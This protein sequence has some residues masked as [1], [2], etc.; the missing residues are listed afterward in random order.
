MSRCICIHTLGIP[1]TQESISQDTTLTQNVMSLV[2]Q[3]ECELVESSRR[4]TLLPCADT[5]TDS[6]LGEDR[7]SPEGASIPDNE[8]LCCSNQNI[9]AN[10][11][12]PTLNSVLSEQCD[13]GNFMTK[14][15]PVFPT[16][17]EDFRTL[18]TL[19]LSIKSLEQQI[20]AAGDGDADIYETPVTVT[21]KSAELLSVPKASSKSADELTDSSYKTPDLHFADASNEIVDLEN[22]E[23]ME[24]KTSRLLNL[25]EEQ[26]HLSDVEENEVDVWE[27]G[28]VDMSSES[29]QDNQHYHTDSAGD[30][31]IEQAV[32]S[33]SSACSWVTPAHSLEHLPVTVSD[34][35]V[36]K[37][38]DL[39]MHCATSSYMPDTRNI[40]EITITP[41]SYLKVEKHE[42]T[43]SAH[44]E[45]NISSGVHEQKED[46]IIA[47]ESVEEVEEKMQLSDEFVEQDVKRVSFSSDDIQEIAESLSFSNDS[48]DGMDDNALLSDES[49][50]AIVPIPKLNIV[51]A[52]C[53]EMFTL[54][55][56]GRLLT[57]EKAKKKYVS[58]IERKVEPR[59]IR[60]QQKMKSV[61]AVEE[62]SEVPFQ[63]AT[64]R[65][66]MARP[67][68]TVEQKVRLENCQ[69]FQMDAF[70]CGELWKEGEICEDY[71]ELFQAKRPQLYH[72]A[73]E[74]PRHARVR[75][76]HTQVHRVEVFH[77]GMDSSLQRTLS[78][79]SSFRALQYADILDVVITLPPGLV[80]RYFLA[81]K[82]FRV[83]TFKVAS[84]RVYHKPVYNWV[85]KH[86]VKTYDVKAVPEQKTEKKTPQLLNLDKP[87]SVT[88]VI[89]M[90][91]PEPAMCEKKISRVEAVKEKVKIET[92]KIY[93]MQEIKPQLHELED[94]SKH[95]VSQ[96][97]VKHKLMKKVSEENKQTSYHKF[98]NLNEETTAFVKENEREER[99]KARLSEIEREVE[100][101]GLE[102]E[103]AR[104]N[105]ALARKKQNEEREAQRAAQ[106]AEAQRKL[107]EKFEKQQE[108][109]SNNRQK[110]SE[111]TKLRKKKVSPPQESDAVTKRAESDVK[112]T[113]RSLVIEEPKPA[114][115]KQNKMV[116]I[117]GQEVHKTVAE[118]A[119][120]PNL[121]QE[122]SKN[123][124]NNYLSNNK[125]A[126]VLRTAQ[127]APN[128]LLGKNLHKAGN[129][130][131]RNDLDFSLQEEQL[132]SDTDSSLADSQSVASD[133]PYDSDS[134][135]NSS[136]L[137][138]SMY[139]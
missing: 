66:G 70:N 67:S 34:C 21:S 86:Q 126:K 10:T 29:S 52:E 108:V 83:Q 37:P 88:K 121:P 23:T 65:L 84:S 30:N 45:I 125:T 80:V 74:L 72:R 133:T 117:N 60:T 8:N 111:E 90:K 95:D 118:Q 26:K 97:Y 73:T 4:P 76:D 78:L 75:Y 123:K 1:G 12:K 77:A 5:I 94:P 6:I 13:F 56:S 25:G 2:D 46:I 115:N 33:S 48:G 114:R 135:A 128:L 44:T 93:S 32:H 101:Q 50:D 59:D 55:E 63:Q 39:V 62:I 35:E 61:T 27:Y 42:P 112:S 20:D 107:K 82:I 81:D 31:N 9:P 138:S 7:G 102:R 105:A 91:V 127:S 139:R 3:P 41:H 129:T 43:K 51:H 71:V 96:Q 19:N 47:E 68:V 131:P 136:H 99:R 120:P 36:S 64:R 109:T 16:N 137:R 104:Q 17:F 119:E 113:K 58:I 92:Q 49:I 22:T 79:E 24:L 89:T 116:A 124:V 106:R 15:L 134:S 57:F 100:Q 103:M 11:D 85:Y 122:S 130:I 132:S 18:E 54:L 38:S 28:E 87:K 98:E 69:V 53:I 14:S 40:Q 110:I